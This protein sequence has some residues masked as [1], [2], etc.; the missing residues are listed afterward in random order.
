MRE[1]VSEYEVGY[2]GDE[3]LRKSGAL[4]MQRMTDKMTVCLRKLAG[5]RATEV[6]FGRWLGNEKVEIEE[7]ISK[8]TKHVKDIV[9][10]LHVLAIQDTTELNYQSHA[11]RV[12]GLGT[13]GNGVDAGL[14]LH[15]MLTVDANSG[16]CLGISGIHIWLR[17]K[18]ASENYK[19]LPIEEKE[20]YRW[21][22][23]AKDS[24]ENL[25]KASKITIIADRESDIYEEWDRI[26]DERTNL[27]IRACRDRT[28]KNGERL[29]KYLSELPVVETYKLNVPARTGKRSNHEAKLEVRFGQVIIERPKNCS[30]KKAPKTINLSAIEIKER[31][32]TVIGAEEPIHW[33]IL[34]TYNIEKAEDARQ[35]VDWYCQRWNIEQVFRI[36]KKQ[37]LDIESSQVETGEGLMKL[38]ILGLQTAVKTM[39]LTL[40]RNNTERPVS[41][42]FDKEKI[43]ILKAMQNKLEGKT[44]KQKNPYPEGKLAWAAWIIARLGGW[45]GYQSESVAGPITMHRGQITFNNICQGWEL[46]KDVCID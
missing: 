16:A 36:L 26:P 2:F 5:D 6:R 24:K 20:S 22:K 9:E 45:K 42:V 41:D 23:V 19:K 38:S 10:G 12:K 31:E 15:P 33:K 27:I 11:G 17:K 25:Q 4:L 8:A 30:D 37:G 29:Y 3:R 43:P 13:V 7:L 39:Q 21:L 14:F 32:E 35:I 28:L 46:S 40:S 18:E 44:E 34:T 1:I